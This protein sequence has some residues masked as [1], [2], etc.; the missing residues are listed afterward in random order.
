MA[1]TRIKNGGFHNTSCGVGTEEATRGSW[2]G[3]GKTGW[4][5]SE[6]NEI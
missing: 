5:L 6:E 1:G 2:D 4:T 3:Q